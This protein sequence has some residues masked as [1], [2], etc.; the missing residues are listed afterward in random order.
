MTRKTTFKNFCLA[1][2]ACVHTNTMLSVVVQ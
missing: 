1:Y 2:I